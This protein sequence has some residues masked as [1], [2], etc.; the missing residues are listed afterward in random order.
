MKTDTT[1]TFT[2]E[3]PL[4]KKRSPFKH[5]EMSARSTLI[6]KNLPSRAFQDF[7]YDEIMKTSSSAA[8][9]NK[10]R[11]SLGVSKISELRTA[12]T[13]MRSSVASNATSNLD[14]WDQARVSTTSFCGKNV[15]V[16]KNDTFKPAEQMK[17][18]F[19]ERTVNE[20]NWED[21]AMKA[22]EMS[23]GKYAQNF[24]GSNNVRDIYSKKS[25]VK[26][27][28]GPLIEIT[29]NDTPFDTNG[30]S[31]LEKLISKLRHI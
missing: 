2:F 21:G 8:V 25:P 29:C 19:N 26:K 3:S 30:K 5:S 28:R 15:P 1:Q 11:E 18:D 7:D 6:Q 24:I 10:Y 20:S 14:F 23:F 9:R 22:P 17:W 31:N 4:N 27:P 16:N 13:S 12:N